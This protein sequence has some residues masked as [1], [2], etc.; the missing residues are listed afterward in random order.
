MNYEDIRCIVAHAAS[1][2]KVIREGFNEDGWDTFV[3]PEA[4]P[5]KIAMIKYV[6]DVSKDKNTNIGEKYKFTFDLKK[7]K[8]PYARKAFSKMF[9]D[10]N[11][12]EKDLTINF[13]FVYGDIQENINYRCFNA[14]EMCS[15][16]QNRNDICDDNAV[17]SYY[18]VVDT[19]GKISFRAPYAS[20]NNKFPESNNCQLN[21]AN[22]LQLCRNYTLDDWQRLFNRSFEK[23][24]KYSL[25][26]IVEECKKCEAEKNKSACKQCYYENKFKDILPQNNFQ[27]RFFTEPRKCVYCGIKEEQLK[28]LCKQTKR[29]GRGDRLEYDRIND[30]KDYAIDNVVLA[31][32]WC[33]NAKS[34]EYSPAEF[35]EIARGI[36]RVWNHRFGILRPEEKVEFPEYSDIWNNHFNYNKKDVD[37]SINFKPYNKEDI[38]TENE[39]NY[40][41][42][43]QEED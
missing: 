26:E 29:S 41:P 31:C 39:E 17:G 30:E 36:N 15:L 10:K 13:Y 22:N 6:K 28:D 38:S 42:D 1:E 2:C 37:C 24:W 18:I 27:E 40:D 19:H 14:D 20:N 21:I 25:N 23:K 35:K 16:F 43:S 12:N 7:I 34:D 3:Y 9:Q 5:T 11:C 4:N 33:N 8:N 32:Y